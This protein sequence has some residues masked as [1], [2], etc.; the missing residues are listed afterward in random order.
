M[1]TDIYCLK[2]KKFTPNTDTQIAEINVKGKPRKIQ[3]AICAE[4]GKKK[5]RF[6][7]T[8]I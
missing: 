6:I 2:C 7:K 5:N 4:C 1:D 3:K 8:S